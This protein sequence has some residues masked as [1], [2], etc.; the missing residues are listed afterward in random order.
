MT[1]YPEGLARALEA[2]AAD[3]TPMPEAS[4]ATAHL[5]ITPPMMAR[6]KKKRS[7]S[8]W[9]S[10]PPIEERVARLRAI[11]QVEA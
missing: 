1:R 11:G 4:R 5:F 8:L 2:L 9:S 6:G 10:H 3:S 7:G